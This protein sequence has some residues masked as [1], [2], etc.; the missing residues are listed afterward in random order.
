MLADDKN[1]RDELGANGKA[2]ANKLFSVQTAAQQIV[3]LG[4]SRQAIS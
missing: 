3:E 1:L 4:F 2:L